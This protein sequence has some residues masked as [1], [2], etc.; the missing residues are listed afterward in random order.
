[1]DV[2]WFEQH[3]K[4]FQV[5][6]EPRFEQ[7]I[8]A[9]QGPQALTVLDKIFPKKI[10]ALPPF[11]VMIENTWQIARTGYTGEDGI[12][13]II[14]AAEAVSFWQKLLT[15]G[16][17]PCGLGA[18]DT[19]RL[20]AG[21][22][23]YG[24]DMNESTTP[25]ESNLAWTVAWQ[26]AQRDFIGREALMAQQNQGIKQQLV[27]LVMKQPGV[28][29]NHQQIKIGE[30]VGE[31]TSGS[32]SP[33]LGY[34]IALARIPILT[35]ATAYVERRGEWIPVDIIKPPFVKREKK[36]AKLSE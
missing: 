8:I 3:A 31:I 7:A 27:G 22:N 25:L 29:R 35:T 12:E 15:A 5:R 19:L 20:E 28:L 2:A 17:A 4:P 34:A 32:F 26:D 18:R 1:V 9:I 21:L 6:I 16:V 14:P 33:T 36:Y 11:G 23:L 10:Q 24:V 13:V 30:T